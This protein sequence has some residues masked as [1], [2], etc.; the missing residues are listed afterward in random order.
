MEESSEIFEKKL[1]IL[2]DTE[3]HHNKV[4][5]HLIRELKTQLEKIPQFVGI[6]I[7]GSTAKGYNTK[8]SDIDIV[9]LYDAPI[10]S[11]LHLWQLGK[12][13]EEEAETVGQFAEVIDREQ[14]KLRIKNSKHLEASFENLNLEDLARRIELGLN[15]FPAP[16][17][18]H[19]CGL[20]AG[21]NVNNYR[22]SVAK[23]VN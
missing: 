18:V 13:S 12:M 22:Q 2:R 4:E 7:K 5:T 8:L 17:L 15:H 16:A 14:K 3:G 9:V 23:L 20:T 10:E 6:G 21:R 19:L 1:N 11:N